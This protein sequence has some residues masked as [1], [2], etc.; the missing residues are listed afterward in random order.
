VKAVFGVSSIKEARDP[1]VSATENM[2]SVPE[3]LLE[4]FQLVDMHVLAL[5][6]NGGQ[7]GLRCS[8]LMTFD[9]L[10]SMNLDQYQHDVTSTEASITC[11]ISHLTTR[12]HL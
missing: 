2:A 4:Q 12:G 9:F 6:F 3:Q 8:L 1:I 11:L 10:G 7:G 5:C